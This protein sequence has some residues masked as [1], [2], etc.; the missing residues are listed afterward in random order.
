MNRFAG[1]LGRYVL[2][3]G[4][5]ACGLF[6]ANSAAGHFWAAGGPPN[7]HREFDRTWGELF[8]TVCWL[9]FALAATV[10]WL[11]LHWNDLRVRRWVSRIALAAYA[12]VLVAHRNAPYPWQLVLVGVAL[13]GLAAL[14]TVTG[15]RVYSTLGAVGLLFGLAATV[16]G[17]VEVSR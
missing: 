12:L 13:T 4:L 16:K 5:F 8:F 9:L 11:P 1:R 7:A 10:A 14:T 6:F 2:A 17:I 15:P 3:L